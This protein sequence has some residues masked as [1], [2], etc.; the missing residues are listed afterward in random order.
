MK[1][2]YLVGIVLSIVMGS[3]FNWILCCDISESKEVQGS[4][5]I[6]GAKNDEVANAFVIED[7]TGEFSYQSD[8]NI[9]FKTSNFI[10]LRP[11]SPGIDD[12]ITQL[13]SYISNQNNKFVDITGYY[14]P[15]EENPSAFPNLGLARA[16]SVK[17]YLLALGVSSKKMNIH[18]SSQESLIRKSDSVI[19]GPISVAIT[20]N[21][22]VKD[23]QKV[24]DNIKENPIVLHF[25]TGQSSIA[26]TDAQ[27]DKY[28]SIVR[29][30]D[31]IDNVSILVEGHTDQTGTTEGNLILGKKRAEFI[32]GYLVENG[33]DPLHIQT[34][35][36]GQD[37]PISDND[38]DQG[39][40]QNRR[41]VITVN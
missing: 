17:N 37:Q 34:V 14:D 20:E 12:G 29:A 8:E 13:K 3:F 6:T 7:H 10:I 16:N 27:R 23:A 15:I 28:L 24:I 18:G 2:A 9:K 25:D 5:M 35:S 32:K 36:K 38:T 11:V 1:S 31:K 40:A 4:E 30:L 19:S 22:M 26:L 21:A 41:T 39:R 33:V